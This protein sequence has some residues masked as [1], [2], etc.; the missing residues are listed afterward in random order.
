MEAGAGGSWSLFTH[1]Q[2]TEGEVNVGAQLL[3]LLCSRELQPV[4]SCCLHSGRVFPPPLKLSK[5]TMS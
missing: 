5:K 1:S 4:G 2:E 3:F